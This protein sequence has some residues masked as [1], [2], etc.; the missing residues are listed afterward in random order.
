MCLE[1]QL[2]LLKGLLSQ[3]LSYPFALHLK[4]TVYSPLL[5]EQ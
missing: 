3:T 2:F 1:L 4:I 5:T